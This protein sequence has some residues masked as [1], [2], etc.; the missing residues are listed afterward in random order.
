M[1][2]RVMMMVIVA[3]LVP[4][5]VVA[6]TNVL[7]YNQTLDGCQSV[8][9]VQIP[10]PFGIGKSKTTGKNC[11]MDERFELTCEK[12]S[13]LKS[14][15]FHVTSINV[16]KG[17]L[18]ML[19][20]VSKYC[21][22]GRI[23]ETKLTSIPSFT[24]S[25]NENKFITVGCDAFGYLNSS[26]GGRI[27]STGCLSRCYGHSDDI[28]SGMCSGFGCC[29]MDIPPNMVNIS[30]QAASFSDFKESLSFNNF[31]YSF[32]VKNGNYT[33]NKE[34]LKKMPLQFHKVPVIYDWSVGN[35]QTGKGA[36]KDN[37]E[38]VK[39]NSNDES[40][41]YQCRCKRGFEGNPY[42]PHDIDEC[43]RRNHTCPS[44]HNCHNTVGSYECICPKGQFEDEKRTC[45]EKN[46]NALPKYAIVKK[47]WE[48]EVHHGGEEEQ[49]SWGGFKIFRNRIPL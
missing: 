19:A 20:P 35:D 39:S 5:G 45:R 48:D 40:G 44:D 30:F 17:Q 13:I 9:G 49:I 7:D 37:S 6:A 8:C 26:Y 46:N 21:I 14:G 22:D 2:L 33:F 36:C 18:E 16:T 27:Y 23:E 32:I 25:A 34:H 47:M 29:Q 3:L 11:F 38:C 31:S 28:V 43:E 10:Y 12:N 42:H 1:E 4:L 41:G 24:V 15:E